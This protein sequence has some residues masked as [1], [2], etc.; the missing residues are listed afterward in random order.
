MRGAAVDG[1][2]T[3]VALM[4]TVRGAAID[5][6]FVAATVGGA[7]DDGAFVAATVGR[8]AVDGAFHW[9]KK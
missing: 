7:A 1:R 6:T 9:M 2:E 4:T 3:F 8:A 5:G